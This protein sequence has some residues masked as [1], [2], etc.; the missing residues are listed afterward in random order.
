MAESREAI[1]EG[2]K[3]TGEDTMEEGHEILRHLDVRDHRDCVNGTRTKAKR[4]EGVSSGL[5]VKHY[6]RR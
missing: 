2:Q 4:V 5:R 1:E 3:V 6:K